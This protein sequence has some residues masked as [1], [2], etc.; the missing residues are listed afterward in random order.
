MPWIRSHS[1]IATVALAVTALLLTGAF[2][3]T[4]RA[5]VLETASD[6][7]WAGGGT[8]AINEGGSPALAQSE[9]TWSPTRTD[10]G[11]ALP[12]L[13]PDGGAATPTGQEPV[14]YDSRAIANTVTPGQFLDEVYALIPK[15]LTS[16]DSSAPQKRSAVQE[17]LYDYGNDV[18][19][20]IESYDS[21]YGARQ[22][23]IMRDFYE[24]STNA[25]KQAAV[26]ALAGALSQ[27]GDD[28][29]AMSDR[30]PSSMAALNAKLAR[31]YQTIGK[32]LAAIPAAKGDAALLSAISAYD[33]SVDAFSK[34]FISIAT[35]LSAAGVVFSTGDPGREFTFSQSTSL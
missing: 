5:P 4:R 31:G 23:N 8:G 19:R 30:I 18:G 27:V 35:T 1:F 17:A 11:S 13:A 2:I 3:V 10:V 20:A 15:G 28:L 21:Q 32:N 14:I 6:V 9:N 25:D 26:V 29:D 34:T 7:S 12:M 16:I 22:A 24:D 33:D